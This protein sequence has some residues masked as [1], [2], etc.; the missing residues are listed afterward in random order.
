MGIEVDES[1]NTFTDLIKL[2]LGRVKGVAGLE[3]SGDFY[4]KSDPKKFKDIV[5]MNPPLETKPYYLM[6]SHQFIKAHSA[7]AE[8]L[9]NTIAQ[10]RESEAFHQMNAKYLQ[11]DS[12][13]N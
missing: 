13:P 2:T 9:W 3:L 11:S 6:F 8:T 4:L 12:K 7:L 5:K 10:I 1:E